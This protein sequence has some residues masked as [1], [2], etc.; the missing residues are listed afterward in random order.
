MKKS[1]MVLIAIAICSVIP[2]SA[3]AD[4]IGSSRISMMEGDVLFQTK[5]AGTEW[6]TTSINMPLMSGDRIWVPETGRT[7]I[8]FLGG[9]YIRAD[10]NTAL[11]ITRL[12]RDSEGNITQVAVTRGRTYIYCNGSSGSTSVFQVD[13][14]LISAM[15]YNSAIFD[16]SVYED[17][18]TEIS[19][20]KGTVFVEGQSASTKVNMGYMISV[21]ADRYAK[22][23]ARRSNDGWLSWNVSRDS[24]IARAGTSIN[25]LPSSL[26]D[27]GSDFDRHGRWVHT[28]DYGYVWSPRVTVATWAP[29]SDGRWVWRNHDYIWVSYEP[30][31][32]VPY[33]YGRWGFGVG[34]GWFWV[35]PAVNDVFWGPGFVAWINTPTYVSWVPLAPREIYYGHGHYGRHSVNVTKVNIKNINVTNVYLNAKVAHAVRVVHHDTFV[36]GK[37]VKVTNAPANPFISGLMVS[38]GR[39]SVKQVN[40]SPLPLKVV[41]QRHLP[42]KK[43]LDTKR[44]IGLS[45]R[46]IASNKDN[47]ALKGK[48]PVS[49]VRANVVTDQKS[50]SL[51]QGLHR[52]KPGTAPKTTKQVQRQEPRTAPPSNSTVGRVE[53]KS[54]PQVGKQVPQ[55]ELKNVIAQN[56]SQTGRQETKHVSSGKN[57]KHEIRKEKKS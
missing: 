32:W 8:Q 30:W 43:V 51:N 16:V 15:A 26:Y 20:I 44:N 50:I 12:N 10:K 17:G 19:V 47:S 2:F 48:T 1:L 14:P 5:D 37:R 25:Y 21:S 9:S 49:P 54:I 55:R 45:G 28:A 52:V 36:K 24:L 34:I 35:P 27:Y 42:P 41:Q 38:A 6:M 46:N 33:H 22:L 13:T 31:G 18:Y 56:N 39:P 57:G 11:D 53:P 40:H 7:E 4:T 3:L 29:Y 23:S